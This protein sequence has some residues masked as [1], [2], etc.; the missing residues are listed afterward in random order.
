MPWFRCCALIVLATWIAASSAQSQIIPKRKLPKSQAIYVELRGLVTEGKYELASLLLQQFLEANPSPQDYIEIYDKYG[1]AAYS[2]L[3]KVP[4]W[5]DNPKHNDASRMRVEEIVRRANAALDQHIRNPQRIAKYIANLGAT[6]EERVYAQMELKRIG[7]VAVPMM[8]HAL[9]TSDQPDLVEGI[10]GT[11]RLMDPGA[12]PAWVAALDGL[13]PPQQLGVINAIAQR[14]DFLLLQNH[15]QTT[16]RP[17]LWY[18]LLH[19]PEHYPPL[20]RL[21]ESLLNQ[22]VTDTGI[23]LHRRLPEQEL[24]TIAREFYDH[25][26]RY[27]GTTNDPATSRTMTVLWVW[28]PAQQ[29][30]IKKDNIPTSQVDEYYGLR[31]CRWILRYR[32]DDVPTQVLFVSLVAGN[33]VERHGYGQLA[34]KDPAAFS[35]LNDAP[36]AVMEEAF[37]QALSRRRTA[38]LVGLLQVIAARG[39]PFPRAG[40]ATQGSLLES[41]LDY[42]DMSVQYLAATALL[43]SGVT[44]SPPA[45]LKIVDIFR[46]ILNESPTT[47][48]AAVLCDPDPVRREAVAAAMRDSGFSVTPFTS[49]REL[50]KYLNQH[51]TDLVV[52]DRHVVQPLL[53]DLLNVLHNDPRLAA[54]PTIVVASPDRVPP[55]TFD[56]LLLRAAAMIAATEPAVPQIPDVYVVNPMDEPERQK[57]DRQDNQLSRDRALSDTFDQRLARLRRLAESTSLSL[58]TAQRQ[59]L[60]LRLAQI[61]YRVLAAE[62]PITQQAA[63]STYEQWQNLEQLLAMQPAVP[64]YGEGLPTEE[65]LT[66]LQRLEADVDRVPQARQRFEGLITKLAPS[67]LGI[68][69][70]PHRDVAAEQQLNRLLHR[71][72]QFR[73]MPLPMSAREVTVKWRPLILEST[74]QVTA[75]P[76][77]KA[78]SRKEAISWLARMASGSIGGYDVRPAVDALRQA[79]TDDTLAPV[80]IEALAALPQPENQHELIAVALNTARPIPIRLQAAEAAILHLRR[81]GRLLAA[82]VAKT[83]S[84]AAA[85]ESHP[86]LRSRILILRSLL[87]PHAVSFPDVTTTY[88]PSVLQPPAAKGDAPQGNQ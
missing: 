53:S 9:R 15:A 22:L 28:D 77:F 75:S 35:V 62:Y 69:L 30:L 59:L 42:P 67:E 80:A 81:H 88:I 52:I 43:R 19:P 58:S 34:E 5:S 61:T 17:H 79:V 60:Q 51:N 56:Q 31:Y 16:I 45:R 24:F 65:L 83:L 55:P 3:L 40:L 18:I 85:G 21:A 64:P 74:R 38:T 14:D 8:V 13:S 66:L 63:P 1:P 47:A 27:W 82:N 73:S 37:R 33:A 87:N 54:I 76:L 36:T 12:I 10:Y 39:E 84:K 57:R 25:N 23:P 70:A 72:P 71:Y 20:R 7:D 46:R 78:S 11:I 49:G 29:R 41:G 26:A 32:P 2:L 6:P 68:T 44:V 48:P 4:K 50:L 86:E